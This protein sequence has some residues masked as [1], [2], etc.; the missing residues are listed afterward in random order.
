MGVNGDTHRVVL[1]GFKVWLY[2]V[3]ELVKAGVWLDI[4]YQQT[5]N[6][7]F[8]CLFFKFEVGFCVRIMG[9][10]N[11]HGFVFVLFCNTASPPCPLPSPAFHRY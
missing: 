11:L 6:I 5:I 8:N 9:A 3:S 1:L 10:E 7:V 2:P 4:F